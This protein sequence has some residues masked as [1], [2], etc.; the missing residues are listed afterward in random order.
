MKRLQRGQH[1]HNS[2]FVATTDL[3]K[4]WV[5]EKKKNPDT[6][7]LV[8]VGKFYEVFNEDADLFHDEFAF[9]YMAGEIAHTGYPE[10]YH[11][12]YTEL[13]DKKALKFTILQKKV[14]L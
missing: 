6:I 11:Q 3:Q 13:L 12:K 1:V 14:N 8:K 2:G 9:M 10:T 5:E 4:K 7:I